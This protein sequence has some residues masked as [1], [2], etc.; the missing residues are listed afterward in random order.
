MRIYHASLNVQTDGPRTYDVTDLITREVTTCGIHSGLVTVFCQHT[1]CSLV[2]MENASPEARRDLEEYLN[3]LV[4][5]DPK[6]RH[7]EEGP[8]DMP[9][10]IK[11]ALTRT[12]ESLPIKD[13]QLLLGTW[14]GLFLWEHRVAPHSRHLEL[15][16]I[17]E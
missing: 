1:S 4:P 12:S 2:I 16:I 9:S 11:T 13:G 8:D 6:F 10:H 15:V 3:R 17:G 14:Q 5:P 7:D